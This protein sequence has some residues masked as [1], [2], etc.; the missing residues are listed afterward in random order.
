MRWSWSKSQRP[1]RWRRR[2]CTRDA[3]GTPR[4]RADRSTRSLRICS[5]ICTAAAP[6]ARRRHW[7][8]CRGSS[9]VSIARC[10]AHA[11]SRRCVAGGVGVVH[12]HALTLVMLASALPLAAVATCAL[13]R[14]VA[15]LVRGSAAIARACSVARGLGVAG[16]AGRARR[17]RVGAHWLDAVR[18]PRSARSEQRRRF[19]GS[20]PRVLREPGGS[21]SLAG[22]VA[23]G[24]PR[25]PSRGGAQRGRGLH[26]ARRGHRLRRRAS[27]GTPARRAR[28]GMLVARFE[29]R[30]DVQRWRFASPVVG[31][32][33]FRTGFFPAHERRAGAAGDAGGVRRMDLS[34]RRGADARAI[35]LGFGP[36]PVRRVGAWSSAIASP[37]GDRVAVARTPPAMTRTDARRAPRCGALRRYARPLRRSARRRDSSTSTIPTT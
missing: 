15:A 30:G 32:L 7:S 5:S 16:V 9:R 20:L 3:A 23:A 10:A 6:S 1:R 29:D 27:A 8:S 18:G 35:D 22:T 34:R 31:A 19:V 4:S 11:D 25:R 26:G 17:S 33:E 12:A 14:E 36:T 13:L 28:P 24:R 2:C 37:R 21:E